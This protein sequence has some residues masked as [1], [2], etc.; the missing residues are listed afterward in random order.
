MR[1]HKQKHEVSLSTEG[2]YE[3]DGK[4]TTPAATYS[5]QHKKLNAF[6]QV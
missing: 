3:K 1:S 2:V 4:A 5:C 6:K